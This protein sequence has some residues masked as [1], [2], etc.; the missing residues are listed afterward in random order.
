MLCGY[1]KMVSV[2]ML[3]YYRKSLVVFVI[4]GVM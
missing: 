2:K 4:F 1:E 3:I